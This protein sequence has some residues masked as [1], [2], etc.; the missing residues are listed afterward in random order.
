MSIKS[1]LFA[2]HSHWKQAACSRTAY[3]STFKTIR[4]GRLAEYADSTESRRTFSK[5]V[6]IDDFDCVWLSFFVY[7]LVSTMP[8]NSWASCSY[9][10]WCESLENS[11]GDWTSLFNPQSWQFAHMASNVQWVGRKGWRNL[12]ANPNKEAGFEPIS[13]CIIRDRTQLI[14]LSKCSNCKA[15]ATVKLFWK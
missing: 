10:I 13:K 9:K 15:I 12:L 14:I 1:E 3:N 4:D 5:A 7:D 11:A 2:W 8:T 6:G